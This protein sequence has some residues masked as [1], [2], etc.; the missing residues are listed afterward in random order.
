MF[1]DKEVMDKYY[2]Y[3][4]VSYE[5]DF[6][7]V[8]TH[9]HSLIKNE[10]KRLSSQDILEYDDSIIPLINYSYYGIYLVEKD[11]EQSFRLTELCALNG[12]LKCKTR[13]A[14]LLTFEKQH[15]NH[16]RAFGLIKELV[17]ENVPSAISLLGYYYFNGVIVNKSVKKAIL[18]FKR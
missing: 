2:K 17:K 9:S 13:L 10:I 18:C 16:Q 6:L 8:G 14:H 4:F 3:T 11:R 1:L 7:A 5:E 12:S 15:I